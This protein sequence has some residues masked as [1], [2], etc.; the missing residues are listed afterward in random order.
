[1]ANFYNDSTHNID[2][3][4][5]RWDGA[6]LVE[7]HSIP[8]NGAMALRYFAIGREHYLAAANYRDDATHNVLS[9]RYRL[10]FP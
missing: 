1:M 3:K 5:Y 8:T 7:A 6:A 10:S 9:K 2:S 4:V